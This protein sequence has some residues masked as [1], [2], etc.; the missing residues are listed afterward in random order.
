MNHLAIRY[1]ASVALL[2]MAMAA[3]YADPIPIVDQQNL[4]PISGT[5][6]GVLFGQ[7]F[8]PTLPKI[9]VI[10]FLMADAGGTDVVKI[11]D[12]VVGFDGLGGPVIGTSDPVYVHT[13]GFH[14]TIQ[15]PFLPGVMLVPGQ[16]YVALLSRQDGSGVEGVSFSDNLY[17]GGQFLEQ[18]FS[19]NSFSR[20]MIFSEGVTPEPVT[21]GLIALGLAVLITLKRVLVRRESI[22]STQ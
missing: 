6:G 12:G 2:N 21:I 13:P 19:L 3:V 18:G 14:E 22:R 7:S 15:F 4:A 16:T 9:D 11:L 10:E 20:D 8:I 1:L 5:N 17:P